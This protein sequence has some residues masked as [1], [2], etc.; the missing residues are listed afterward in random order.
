[1]KIKKKKLQSRGIK[2]YIKD[3]GAEIG[4]A[5]LYILR[6][7]LHQEPF[8]FIEDVYVNHKFRGQGIGAMLVNEILKE[9]EKQKCYKIIATNRYS[10]PK[11]YKLYQDLGLR[12]YGKEF[13]LDL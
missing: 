1:M 13:R 5:Y 12:D 10:R 9:A 4:R 7:D 2:F 11:G 6:N 8:G 3:E